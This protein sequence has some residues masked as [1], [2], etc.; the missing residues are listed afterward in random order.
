MKILE[1]AEITPSLLERL[2]VEWEKSGIE[3]QKLEMLFIAP[4]ERGKGPGRE[5]IQYGLSCL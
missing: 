4:Q 3:A 1:V 2:I 5:F